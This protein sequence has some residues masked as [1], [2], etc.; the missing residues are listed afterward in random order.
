M[1][2]TFFWKDQCFLGFGNIKKLILIFHENWFLL[3][4]FCKQVFSRSTGLFWSE[5]FLRN[6][7]MED[8]PGALRAPK[9]IQEWTLI[10]GRF[11]QFYFFRSEISDFFW[12]ILEIFK[13]SWKFNTKTDGSQTQLRKSSIQL[14]KKN[15][16]NRCGA[17]VPLS[18]VGRE[19]EG[20]T[21]S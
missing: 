17:G 12:K 16:G 20:A 10:F 13:K 19:V 11:S 6:S 8:F 21:M 4:F 18:A 5:F 9:K 3:I 1:N 7:Q 14:R 15:T 2:M